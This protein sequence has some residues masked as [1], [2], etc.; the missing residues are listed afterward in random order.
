MTDPIRLYRVT[1]GIPAEKIDHLFNGDGH[2]GRGS[3]Y[4]LT[5]EEA[6]AWGDTNSK[7]CI[8]SEVMAYGRIL[9]IVNEHENNA[10]FTARG[11]VDCEQLR[12]NEKLGLK[13]IK[14]QEELGGIAVSKGYDIIILLG[15]IDGGSQAIIPVGSNATVKVISMEE[16]E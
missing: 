15:Y 1:S 13:K 3:Y 5:P 11:T 8:I 12:I 4:A 2:F 9:R 16:A 6:L 7:P 14:C 10:L